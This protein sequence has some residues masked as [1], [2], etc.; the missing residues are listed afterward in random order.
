MRSEARKGLVVVVEVVSFDSV[1]EQD[2]GGTFLHVKAFEVVLISLKIAH[3]PLKGSD[4]RENDS[5]RPIGTDLLP[6]VHN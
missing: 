6:S 1:D 3:R 4:W 5:R 2:L